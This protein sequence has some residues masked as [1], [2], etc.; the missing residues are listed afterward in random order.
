MQPE[1]S[2]VVIDGSALGGLFSALRER[3]YTIVGPTERDGAIQL[4]ELG[5]ATDLPA[6]RGCATEAGRY[7]LLDRPD[8][9]VFA[10]CAGPCGIKDLLHPPRARLWSAE[11]TAEGVATEGPEPSERRFAFLGVHPCD[12]AALAVLDGVLAR[13]EHPDPVYTARRDGTL[14]IVAEC[15]EPGATCFCTSMGAGPAAT[16]GFD[17]AL[18]ELVEGGHRFVARPGSPAGAEG[19]AALDAQPAG[20]AD[21]GAAGSA[22]ENAADMITRRMP[23]EPL[24]DLIRSTRDSA[25]WDDV[26]SRCLAC[27]NC[28]MVCPTCFCVTTE[29]VSDLTGQHTERLA[30]VGL[31]FQP[32]LLLH[33]RRT[34]TNQHRLPVPAV[35]QSQTR[36][37][38]G[39]V[40]HVR[41]RRLRP[42]HRL[43]LGRHRHHPGGRG[44]GREP[45]RGGAVVS[46]VPVP[47]RVVSRR[48]DTADTVTMELAG[49]LP[50]YRPG[51]FA[52]LTAYGIGEAP[53]SLSGSRDGHVI[54]TVRAVG[55]VT[56]ALCAAGAGDVIG[57]RGPFGTEWD[58]GSAAGHD[59]IVVAG[60]IG[61]AP[62]RPVV[63]RMLADRPAFGRV[64]ILAGARLP[65]DLL[66]RADMRRWAAHAQVEVI[67]DRGAPGWRGQVG[68]VT[69]LIP[70][71]GVEA[72]DSVAFVCG[73]EPMM[74]ASARALIERGVPASRIRL[75]L[76]RGMRCGAGWCGHCQ[77][78]PLLICRDGP[79]V[80]YPV[81]EPLLNVREL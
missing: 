30:R 78:G 49:P 69:G 19:L 67:V 32:G 14:V 28:T 5:S 51:Q 79:V 35:D 52:M 15:T 26:A 29:D 12:V 42:V 57:V 4:A 37:L 60:G 81:A 18:T 74:R 23:D 27:G 44:P 1:G 7:R 10:H 64:A 75:S 34:G 47:C 62:L 33:A 65:E 38:A 77:L 9:A 8:S 63:E 22:V 61:L 39:A 11:R 70:A 54:H 48:A 55:A 24:P 46:V 53:I 13:G 43:V 66:Y 41:L 17:V 31:L 80:T 20:P 36:H 6:G 71:A 58:V 56:R 68:L 16:T 45:G 21:I 72:S 25:H 2:T 3:G 73:P 76:E 40:W 50:E 59:V